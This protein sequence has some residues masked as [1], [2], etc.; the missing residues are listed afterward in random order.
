MTYLYY[1][2]NVLGYLVVGTGN[3]SE[4]E[5]GYFTKY[6]DGGVDILPLGSLLKS[7]VRELAREIGIPARIV[8]KV[9][10]AGLW[11]G[12]TDEEELGVSD[13]DLDSYLLGRVGSAVPRAE[14]VQRIEEL[15]SRN[16]HK[17]SPPPIWVPQS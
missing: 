10:S 11:E 4:L 2:A 9:P 6:G 8:Q 12:Q 7:Q 13:A 17:L 14:V 5:V 1:Y 3:R 16:R 15:R